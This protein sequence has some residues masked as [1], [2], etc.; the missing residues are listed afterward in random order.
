MK[1]TAKEEVIGARLAKKYLAK[2]I[3]N[4]PL[5]KAHIARMAQ[6]ILDGVYKRTH[7]GIA[8]NEKGRL[9]DGQ[10]RLSAIIRAQELADK[11]NRGLI[12]VSMLV[13]RNLPM[14]AVYAIDADIRP[15]T[16]TDIMSM[17]KVKMLKGFELL[18]GAVVK[19]FSKLG[20][21]KIPS[22]QGQIKLGRVYSDCINNSL[23][24]IGSGIR[25]KIVS[26]APVMSAL[27][28]AFL[29]NPNDKALI[30]AA[31]ALLVKSDLKLAN[32]LL[33]G[34]ERSNEEDLTNMMLNLRRYLMN[35]SVKN[36]FELRTTEVRTMRVLN[37]YIKGEVLTRF[38]VK[39][40]EEF[41]P[42]PKGK[43]PRELL[44]IPE[45]N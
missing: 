31:G 20:H 34:K 44:G 25:D 24:I 36:E 26:S 32:A 19:R 7:M 33:K 8:F 45:T 2:N 30:A 1:I 3:R 4:R 16:T 41:F 39:T 11:Q 10:N 15:R 14:D 23:G 9:V 12:A 35:S 28:R 22:K 43:S 29:S 6:D 42:F 27:A 18:F 38:T 13:S 40:T 21:G 5:G 17:S 37:A